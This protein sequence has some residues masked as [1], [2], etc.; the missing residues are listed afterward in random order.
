[1][2]HRFEHGP[3]HQP[4]DLRVLGQQDR[5]RRQGAGFF[6]FR[7][8]RQGT[9]FGEVEGEPEGAAL[10]GCAVDADGTVHAAD[11]SFADRQPQAGA[12]VTP[13]GRVLGLGKGIEQPLDLV[14]R[15]ADAAVGDLEPQPPQGLADD[16]FAA[17]IDVD[18]AF[19][20]EFQRVADQVGQHLLQAGR[21]AEEGRRQVGIDFAAKQQL[22]FLGFRREQPEDPLHQQGR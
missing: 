16:R 11:Q 4:I 8:R 15:D 6:G 22:P 1:M 3:R 21:V 19:L 10:A 17:H 14:F 2:S 5:H 9:A 12:A 18:L 7:F 20:G 13:G